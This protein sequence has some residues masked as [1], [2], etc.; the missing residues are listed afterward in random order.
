MRYLISL[1]IFTLILTLAPASSQ[2]AGDP[3]PYADLVYQA[4]NQTYSPTNAIGE[5]DYS[6]A[7]FFA[8][9]A[10]II[11]DMGEGEEGIGDLTM[12]L[13]LLN[14]GA[15]YRVEYRD[16]NQ[17][18]LDTQTGVIPIMTS[19]VVV[20]F[21]GS[22]PYRFVKITSVEEELWKLDAIESADYVGREEAIEEPVI[23]EPDPDVITR[24]SLIKLP[25]DGDPQTQYDSAVYVV[26]ADE[27]R[28]AFPSED[29]FFS[30]FENF[31]TI[32]EV[33][34]ITIASYQLGPNV[35]MRPG[36]FLIKVTTDPNVYAVGPG[37]TLH[38]ITA[39]QNAILLYGENW[40]DRVRDVSDV[41]FNNYQVGQVITS[42]N[43]P[44]AVVGLDKENNLYYINDN[45]YRAVGADERAQ[46]RL[47]SKF[48][49]TLKDIVLMEYNQEADYQVDPERQFPY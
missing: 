26:G 32:Q 16:V 7:E 4:H 20:P 15:T 11:L 30:W 33:D 18:N 49:V 48:F 39:E 29:V 35:T 41:F 14:F 1:F 13:K 43:Y 36:T 47:Q 44:N 31:D 21:N 42:L 45:E 23:E 27:K 8:R 40:A 37:G 17:D 34:P 2:A 3:D 5:H 10:S 25:D 6:Y 19:Q 24:G 9:D 22:Q 46:M 38:W 12:H 28:H